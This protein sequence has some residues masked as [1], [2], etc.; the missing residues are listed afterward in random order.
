[1]NKTITY[2]ELR[3]ELESVNDEHFGRFG[4]RDMHLDLINPVWR[5]E[6]PVE[7]GVNWC[8]CGTQSI[9]DALKFAE[10]LSNACELAKTFKYNGYTVIR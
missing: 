10:Q 1:M 6:G 2:R 4:C 5:G 8:A 3:D 9:A 7:I